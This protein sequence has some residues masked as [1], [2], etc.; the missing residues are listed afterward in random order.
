M[1]FELLPALRALRIVPVIVIDDADAALPLADALCTGGLACAE[2]TF[3]TPAAAD[4]IRRITRERPDLLVGAGTVL[5]AEQVHRAQAAGAK[6]IVAPGF[7]PRVVELCLSLDLPVMPGVV[8]PSEIERAREL[9]VTLLKFFPAEAAGGVRY[10]KAI[11]APY[12][13]VHFVPTGGIA[14]ANLTQY[15]A[16]DNVAACGGSWMAP[17]DWIANREFE[18]IRAETARAVTLATPHA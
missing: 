16:L 12:Q 17:A 7:N 13:G 14:P 5:S 2:I 10:L 6:F 9:G 3:R 1:T 11:G 4:A 18:R 15:L 8:T